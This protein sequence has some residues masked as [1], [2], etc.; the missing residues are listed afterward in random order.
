LPAD[1]QEEAARAYDLA[2]IRIRGLGAV[3]NFGVDCYMD[4][5]MA[6]RPG[7]PPMCM[8]EPEMAARPG[9]PT[10]QLLLLLPNIEVKDEPESPEPEPAPVLREDV[11]DVDRAVA[12]ILETL[13]MDRADFDA[14]YL[15][16]RRRW[17]SSDD[18]DVRDLPVDVGLEVDIE[19]VL[20]NDAPGTAGAEQV[21]PAASH[22]T[23]A[24]TASSFV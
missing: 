18:D 8:A 3:T 19:S 14:R 11:D 21:V 15:P 17:P 16:R 10:P 22:A 24:A 9:P 4:P 1:T 20:F 12:E 6:A 7:S 2:A 23:A 5:D 13:C